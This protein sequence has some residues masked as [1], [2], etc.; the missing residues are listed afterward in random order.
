MRTPVHYLAEKIALKISHLS[1]IATEV[2]LEFLDTEFLFFLRRISQSLH[3]TN[4]QDL[5]ALTLR[6][7]RA[8]LIGLSSTTVQVEER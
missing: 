6:R 1:K 2:G 7:G 5:I 4:D 8:R 3:N